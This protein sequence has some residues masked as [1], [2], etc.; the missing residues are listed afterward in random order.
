MYINDTYSISDTVEVNDPWNFKQTLTY[1][2]DD[3]EGAYLVNKVYYDGFSWRQTL[4]WEGLYALDYELSATNV[5]SNENN[6]MDMASTSSYE[7]PLKEGVIFDQM[8][9]LSYDVSD[10]DQ[11]WLSTVSTGK[12]REFQQKL[13]LETGTWT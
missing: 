2:P 4:D 8:I 5:Y 6:R 13:D 3:G 10:T 7:H 12:G 1:K 9:D 11:T